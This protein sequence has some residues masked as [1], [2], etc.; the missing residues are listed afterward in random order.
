MA[1]SAVRGPGAMSGLNNVTEGE[2]EWVVTPPRATRMSGNVPH[3]LRE[4]S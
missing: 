4:V 2:Q 3:A 1:L